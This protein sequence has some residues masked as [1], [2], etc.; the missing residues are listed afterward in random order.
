MTN[1]IPSHEGRFIE[2]VLRDGPVE[3]RCIEKK[4]K[5]RRMVC[6]GVFNDFEALWDHAMDA[7]QYDFDVYLS[8]NPTKLPVTNTLSR[9]PVATRDK[10]IVS[11]CRLLFDLDPVREAG[12]PASALAI[13]NAHDRLLV[14]KD[15]LASWGPPLVAFSGNGYH[16][17]YRVDLPNDRATS[18]MLDGLYAGLDRLISTAEVSFDVS[19]RNASR[20]IRLYGTR[21]QKSGLVSRCLV[22]E[23]WG[24]IPAHCIRATAKKITPPKRPLPNPARLKSPIHSNS[25]RSGYIP[26]WDIVSAFRAAGLY[27]REA[28]DAGKHYVL[29]PW[30]SVHS[31][32]GAT[33]TVI[34][35]GLWPQFHCSHN[36][37]AGRDIL[38]VI[39]VMNKYETA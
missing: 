34:W 5:Y 16:A 25:M 12:T 33:D 21:N 13:Q 4:S 11:R 18:E 22:P 14:L 10:D 30:A 17:I 24:I 29:C 35:E 38:D 39:Q 37:C 31:E 36:H 28:G 26:N 23:N 1:K 6:A 19:V 2:L 32:T 15:V 8:L 27:L 9:S 3:L 7:E 20:I